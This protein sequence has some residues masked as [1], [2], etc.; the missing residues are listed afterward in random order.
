LG[1]IDFPGSQRM[2][3]THVCCVCVCVC[4]CVC[5]RA[6]VCVCV[7]VCMC[8]RVCV[9]AR[10]Y[11]YACVCLC[12]RVHIEC[13]KRKSQFACTATH[14]QMIAFILLLNYSYFS[15]ILLNPSFQSF[16]FGSI[17]RSSYQFFILLL[18]SSFFFSILHSSSYGV[19]TIS[20]LL[21]ILGLFCKRAL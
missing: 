20:R 10:A 8:V 15:T 11:K 21:E 12:A 2:F 17:H 13:K 4:V 1:P 7:C 5:E 19:A 18:N 16:I 14:N 6:L 9:R 3:C